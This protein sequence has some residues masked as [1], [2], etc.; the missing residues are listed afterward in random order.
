MRKIG[1]SIYP[2]KSSVKEVLQ[3]LDVAHKNGFKRI[4]SC[5][6]SINKP[7]E[8][9]IKEFQEIGSYAKKL[10]FEVILDVSPRIFKELDISYQDLTFFHLLHADGI[11]LDLGY[12]GSEESLMTFNPYDLLIEL[13]MSNNTHYLD[14][15]MDYQPNKYKLVGCH[16][17]Y[18]HRYSGLT[19]EHFT[20]C[21]KRFKKYNLQTSSFIT[22]Q[23]VDTFGPWPVTDGLPTLEMHRELPIDIQLKHYVVMDDIDNIIISNCYPSDDELEKL[24]KVRLDL[25]NLNITTVKGISEV[26]EKIL[27]NELHF[28]RGDASENIIRSTQP[29]VKYRGTHFPVYNAPEII[30]RGDVVIE[31]SEYGHYAGEVQIALNDMINSGKSNVVARV[32]EKE[33]FLLDY[34][35]PWQK[36]VFTKE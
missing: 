5:L 12:S 3:Y 4:F 17:F 35:K 20:E 29:R 7:K 23:N 36:F 28:N 33:I 24:S 11:R 27:F 10:G 26:E 16:N 2:E 1:I 6:L 8:E 13:N 14:T 21:T 34:I 22:S 25:L 32:A 15:V 30:R 19:L 31:S 9:I 18:P